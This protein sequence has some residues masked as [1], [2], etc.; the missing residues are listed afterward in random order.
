MCRIKC[1]K[2]FETAAKVTYFIDII[3]IYTRLQPKEAFM[4]IIKTKSKIQ[5]TLAEIKAEGKTIGFVPTMGA[6]HK[7]H[8]SLIQKSKADTDISV[9]SIFINPTQFNNIVDLQKYPVTIERDIDLLEAAGCDILFLPSTGEMYSEDE[10]NEH[11]D[12]GMLETK[13]EGQ[14]RP[15]HFQGVCIIVDKLLKAVQPTSIYLG[16]KDYQQCMV[17][18]KMIQDKNYDVKVRLC[19]TVREIDG[20][21]MSSRNARLNAEER[22]ISLKIFE[23]LKY[24]Q[25]KIKPGNLDHLKLSATKFLT[26]NGFKVDYTEIADAQTLEIIVEWDGKKKLVTLVAAYLN[27]VRLIDNLI[28]Q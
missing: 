24:I 14:Y 26:D 21:A 15:G 20:L 12:L 10:I 6:L 27:D 16:K 19:D 28:L 23:S 25:E 9:C 8:I 7:G 22:R 17:L 2:K 5:Q 11:Y 18:T 3:P 4:I 13:L 1:K